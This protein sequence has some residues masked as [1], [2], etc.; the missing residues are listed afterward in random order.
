M[1]EVDE[2][3]TILTIHYDQEDRVVQIDFGGQPVY[4]IHYS[5]ATV[6]VKTPA[7]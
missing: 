7:D 3:A 5:G 2:N 6:D 4:R 1:S